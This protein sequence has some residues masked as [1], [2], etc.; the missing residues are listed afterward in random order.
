MSGAAPASDPQPL[1]FEIG[2]EVCWQLGGIYTV[3][4]SKVPAMLERWGDRYFMIG[5]Y[6]PQTAALEFE[7]MPTEGFI[8]GALDQLRNQGIGCHYGRWLVPGLAQPP[9]LPSPGPRRRTR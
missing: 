7:E 6:N 5:P 9:A 8:R 4:R 3:L 2:W 1:L